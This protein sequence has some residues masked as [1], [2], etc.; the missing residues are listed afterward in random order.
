M[1][2]NGQATATGLDRDAAVAKR[3]LND[4][5]ALYSSGKLDE[6]EARALRLAEE[7][8]QAA[9][10]FNLL[11]AIYAGKGQNN[12]AIASYVHAITVKPD[13]AE[14]HYN[15]GVLLW[16]MGMREQAV[17]SYRLALT[18]NPDFAPAHGT[19]ANALRESGQLE[20]AVESYARAIEIRPESP[21]LH[22]NLANALNDLGRFEEG[23][24]ACD[25]ALGLAPESAHAH[26]NR[27][28]SLTGLHRFD[29]A[30]AACKRAIDLM[31][32]LA[33][34]HLNL[35]NIH[36]R[37]NDLDHALKHT[38]E[39][40][41]L[42]PDSPAVALAL[43]V[44]YRRRGMI[45]EAI[46][47]LEPF[48]D[49]QLSADMRGKI[50]SELGKLYD[51][52]RDAAKAFASF[53]I[54]NDLQAAEAQ[55][56]GYDKGRFLDQIAR[57]DRILTQ[58]W[59]GRFRASL[60]AA[61]APDADAPVFLLGFPRSGTTLLDQILDSHPGIQVMEEK[62][63]FDRVI[64]AC[65]QEA[66]DYPGGLADMPAE[67]VRRLRELYFGEV[68]KH[69]TREPGT[70]L[71]DKLPLHIRHLL[72]I[73]RLFPRAKFIL[74]LR[75]P[76]DVVLSNFMQRFKVNDAMANFFSL[77]D[78][79]LC[80]AQVMGHWR[81]VVRAL[82]LDF[83]TLKYE[84]LIADFDVEVGGLLDF[85]GLEWDEAVRGFD[86]HAKQ[87]GE[88]TTP[89]Y[90]AVT[91]PI[92]ARARYRWKRYEERFSPVMHHLAPF[93]EAFGYDDDAEAARGEG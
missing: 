13:F 12:K 81:N 14:G 21:E 38:E 47:L 30:I 42:A 43:A 1:V 60:E 51:G 36:E 6:A 37:M 91:E 24:E 2:K 44:L 69:L 7:Y 33:E 29:E 93:I 57:V 10:V 34:A 85:L 74:A 67:A 46:E 9:S 88:I 55:A 77:E 56:A 78:A 87:R 79:A 8:P 70:L 64:D 58:D 11:G 40:R 48:A 89:S 86:S 72:L 22:S 19:L 76:C 71:V 90:Q 32:E 84:S 49:A 66:G 28:C 26:N 31:P 65:R 75:H 45:R 62:P 53:T 18:A 52:A 5:F 41:R 3:E 15:L 20:E 27:G 39:A 73:L 92:N 59:A 23:L 61:E 54:A 63:V 68:D 83:H 17:A 50:H 16:K 25:R 35:G 4:I 82:P 80:Y